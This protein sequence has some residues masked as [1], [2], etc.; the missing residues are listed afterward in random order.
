MHCALE[1]VAKGYGSYICNIYW[2]RSLFIFFSPVW[3]YCIVTQ[4]RINM[5]FCIVSDVIGLW[6]ARREERGGT[7]D[8]SFG[9][10]WFEFY[11]NGFGWWAQGERRSGSGRFLGEQ[12]PAHIHDKKTKKKKKNGAGE[13]RVFICLSRWKFTITLFSFYLRLPTSH[14]VIPPHPRP[15]C[16][17]F[18]IT[19]SHEAPLPPR[20]SPWPVALR[21]FAGTNTPCVIPATRPLPCRASASPRAVC[22]LIFLSYLG[23][24][25]LDHI[26]HLLSDIYFVSRPLFSLFPLQRH[27]VSTLVCSAPSLCPGAGY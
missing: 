24:Q 26:L 17:F 12:W 15:L 22:H 19:R 11:R 10:Q 18:L 1:V 6:G 7:W 16:S 2:T 14:R 9:L 27:L 21:D 5:S 3:K 4:E 23:R 25:L 13:A 20:A 8:I